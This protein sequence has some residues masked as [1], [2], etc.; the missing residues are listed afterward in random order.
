VIC[1]AAEMRGSGRTYIVSDHLKLEEIVGSV[2]TALK[3][4]TPRRRFPAPLIRALAMAG[5][6]IP[7]FPLSPSRIAALTARNVYRTE[8]ICVELGYENRIP[9]K[10]GIA[11]LA[12]FW[13]QQRGNA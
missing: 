1:A 8:R 4:N 9:L 5:S 10:A 2:A 12:R 7:G 11:E 3:K 6:A 13:K